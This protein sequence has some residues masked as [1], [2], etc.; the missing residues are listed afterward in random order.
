MPSLVLI[1][2]CATTVALLHYKHSEQQSLERSTALTG[3]A[4]SIR[5]QAALAHSV[6]VAHGA[7]HA[8]VA[9]GRDS[10][11]DIDLLTG[12]PQASDTGIAALFAAINDL[13][14]S[15]RGN[16]LIF[17]FAGIP[18]ARCHVAYTTG[19]TSG[20]PPSVTIRSGKNGG[21]CS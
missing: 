11:V 9:L 10:L 8:S 13:E 18:A 3:L 7:A 21:D 16:E 5:S 17:S 6:W 1:I 19:S 2:S 12:F 14:I 20:A 15:R 4:G